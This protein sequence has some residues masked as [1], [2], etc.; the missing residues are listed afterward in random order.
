MN[1]KTREII[2]Y[3]AGIFLLISG[4]LGTFVPQLGLS[5]FTSVVWAVLGAVFLAIAYGTKARKIV[6]YAA[7]IF[8]FIAGIVG[9]VYTTLG[10]STLNSILWL[11]LGVLFMYVSYSVDY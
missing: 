10:I 8:L 7:G 9:L 2:L 3:V 5:I 1:L 4:I 11:L 6:F